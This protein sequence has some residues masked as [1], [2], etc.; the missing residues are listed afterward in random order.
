LKANLISRS[1]IIA[2]FTHG[3]VSIFDETEY[4]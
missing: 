1:E 3:L 4:Q 2:N